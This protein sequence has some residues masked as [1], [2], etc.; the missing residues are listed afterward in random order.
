M[1]NTKVFKVT[2]DW[3]KIVGKTDKLQNHLARENISGMFYLAKSPWL[4]GMCERERRYAWSWRDFIAVGQEKNRGEWKK[5]VMFLHKAHN[6]EQPLQLVCPLEIGVAETIVQ[7]HERRREINLRS[8][9]PTPNV[10][11]RAAHRIVQQ[12]QAE[13]MWAKSD[14]PTRQKW[15]VSSKSSL[16]FLVT[17]ESS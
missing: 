13:H 6:I 9:R 7:P 5:G 4:G 2:A 14:K 11:Q 16:E 1:D 10:A 8:Q 3:I 12:L 17:Y 15:P